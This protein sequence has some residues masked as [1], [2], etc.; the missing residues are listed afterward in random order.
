VATVATAAKKRTAKESVKCR[1][2]VNLALAGRLGS[3]AL[4]VSLAALRAHEQWVLL[5]HLAESLAKKTAEKERTGRAVACWLKKPEGGG[6]R[7]SA[8]EEK[9]EETRTAEAK[10][11]KEQTA[12]ERTAKER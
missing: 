9:T 11:V 1:P 6:V 12:K 4:Q 5:P 3:W 2:A 8:A 10:T 7:Q